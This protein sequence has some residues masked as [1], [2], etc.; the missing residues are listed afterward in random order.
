MIT[1]EV[2]GVLKVSKI[3]NET[4]PVEVR[5]ELAKAE[6]DAGH[7]GGTHSGHHHYLSC[8]LVAEVEGNTVR[9]SA[10]GDVAHELFEEEE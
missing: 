6:N 9:L 3:L 1:F 2:Q 8:G 4:L 5:K 7:E 10:N